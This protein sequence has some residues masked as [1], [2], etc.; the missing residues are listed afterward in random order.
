MHTHIYIIYIYNLKESTQL[1][2]FHYYL[3]VFP[4]T[5]EFGVTLRN[6]LDLSVIESSSLIHPS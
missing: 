3:S 5:E 1:S 4:L 6:I 2:N